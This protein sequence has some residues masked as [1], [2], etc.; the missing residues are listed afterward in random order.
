MSGKIKII[1]SVKKP[2]AK[3]ENF[4]ILLKQ[5]SGDIK[6]MK[7]DIGSMKGDIVRIN[8]DIGSMKGDIGRTNNDIGSIKDDIGSM[9]GDIKRMDGSINRLINGHVE[10]TQKVNSVDEH[11]NSLEGE[12][13]EGFV[14]V[15]REIG[16][17]KGEMGSMR[18]D[19]DANFKEIFEFRDETRA[20][21]SQVLKCLSAIEDELADIKKELRRLDENKVGKQEYA[22]LENRVARLESELQDCKILV[23]DEK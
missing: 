1:K 11:V 9:K 18:R 21:F 7:G 8:N 23:K 20:N 10:L 17:M 16:S 13:R 14:G 2:I 15:W 4:G 12:M 22:S 19:M 5:I 3:K 6:L